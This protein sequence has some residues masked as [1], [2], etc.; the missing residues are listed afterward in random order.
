[1]IQANILN[2]VDNNPKAVYIPEAMITCSTIHPAIQLGDGKCHFCLSATLIHD[3]HPSD[4]NTRALG[5]SE[6]KA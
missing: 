6:N 3:L 5:G 1:M 2:I 4:V